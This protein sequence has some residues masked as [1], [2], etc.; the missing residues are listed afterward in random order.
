MSEVALDGVKGHIERVTFH[1]PDNGFCVLKA[2]VKGQ[3][4]LV[5][6]VGTLATVN[7]GEPFEAQGTWDHHR[8]FG[9]QFKAQSIKTIVPTTLEGIEKYLASGL[10][11][12]VGPG[13][14]AGRP[15][16]R[17]P[18]QLSRDRERISRHRWARL[19]AGWVRSA[20]RVALIGPAGSVMQPA[21]SIRAEA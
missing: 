8:L 18:G 14:A 12:G 2:Q 11:K 19:R 21:S 17:P 9:M 16:A 1:N 6:V 13:W 20:G 7:P 10:I 15:E 4:D 5:T 3:K